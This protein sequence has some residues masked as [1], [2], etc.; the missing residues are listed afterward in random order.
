MKPIIKIL[1]VMFCVF[2]GTTPL[3]AQWVQTSSP[4][5]FQIQCFAESGT[6]LFAGDYE[7]GVFLSTD[8]GKSWTAASAGL[9][10]ATVQ[11]LGMSG[12]D[13]IAGTLSNAIWRRP[14]S[15]MVAGG[16]K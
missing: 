7:D 13:L 10:S 12:M 9:P 11:V 16:S 15:E 14:L 3:L 1:F 4:Q 2:T 8:N 6:N 5:G